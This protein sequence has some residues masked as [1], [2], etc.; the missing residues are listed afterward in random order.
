MIKVLIIGNSF[1]ADVSRY[2][3]GISRAGRSEI[4]VVNLNIGGCSLYRHYR[5]MLSEET[6]YRYEINGIDTGLEVSLKKAL[7]M[8]EW[9]YVVFQQC[10]PQSGSPEKYQPYLSALNEYVRR[11]CPPAEIV[12]HMTWSFAEGCGRFRLTPFET[13]DQLYEAL[14]KTYREAAKEIKADLL[15]PSGIAMHKLYLAI[16]DETYRDGFHCGLGVTRYMLGCLFFMALTGKT[17]DGNRFDDFDV[18]VSEERRLLAQQI[19]KETLLEE[20]WTLKE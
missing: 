15:L 3:N 12:M 13:H 2:L 16:G 11:L 9:N 7:L 14:V 18:E 5:N 8:D 19:A 10:S 17:I 4:R 1:G 20:G 6:V